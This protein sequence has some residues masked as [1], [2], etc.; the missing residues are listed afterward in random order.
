M[1]TKTIYIAHPFS[2][3]EEN[4]REVES[5]IEQLQAKYPEYLFISPIHAFSFAYNKYC[6]EYGMNMC[7]ALLSKC[8]EVW[9]FGDWENSRG[10]RTEHR[11][12][13]EHDILCLTL[14]VEKLLED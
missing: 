3:K 8:D 12:A 5:I 11:F 10:C 9:M 7:L 4:K 14:P 6:Y 2:N 1:F 13:D